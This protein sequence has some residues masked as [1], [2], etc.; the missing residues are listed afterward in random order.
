MELR[1]ILITCVGLLFVLL[2]SGI[3]LPWVIS[4]DEIPVFLI[5]S[6]VIAT[7]GSAAF[8]MMYLFRKIKKKKKVK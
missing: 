5:L 4:S 2:V 1:I 7:F 6:I 8:F 3:F